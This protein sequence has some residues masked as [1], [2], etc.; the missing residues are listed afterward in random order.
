MTGT[1]TKRYPALLAAVLAALVASACGAGGNG[2]AGTSAS[3]SVG[4][5]TAGSTTVLTIFGAASLRDVLDAVASAYGSSHPWISIAT[6]TDSSAALETQIEQGA[7]ADVFLSADTANPQKLFSA[8]LAAGQPVT[9]AAN[10]LAIVVPAS[11]PAAIVTPADLAHSG[12]KIV[13][14]EDSVPISAY[15]SRL[16]ANLAKLPGYPADFAAAYT[17]NVVSREANVAAVAS[18]VA[19]G[20]ADAGIVYATDARATKRVATIPVPAQANVSALYAG[21]A[22]KTSHHLTDAQA[23][24][25]W[26]AGPNGQAVLQQFGFLAPPS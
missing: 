7:P 1:R 21:V 17:R 10:S 11:N 18:K 23:F 20:E 26:L 22:V 9:F 6:S 19:L 14:A 15:A 5:I 3:Q 2:S 12:V 4:G 24:L 25:S 16:I 13:A 8:G